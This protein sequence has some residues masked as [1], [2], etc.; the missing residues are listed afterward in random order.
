MLDGEFLRE[1][2]E[3]VEVGKM[4][5]DM[6][7]EF[8]EKLKEVQKSGKERMRELALRIVENASSI[9][10]LATYSEGWKLHAHTVRIRQ[11][12]IVY[13]IF[14]L[15]Q[16]SVTIDAENGKRGVT[17]IEPELREF[18]DVLNEVIEEVIG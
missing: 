6:G 14:T 15:D 7:R 1:M 4:A 13:E 18:F 3:S 2:L 12:N 9:E 11:G 17:M 8:V 10:R 16:I 5:D